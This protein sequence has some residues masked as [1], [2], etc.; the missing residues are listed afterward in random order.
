[1]VRHERLRVLL[2]LLMIQYPLHT[3]ASTRAPSKSRMHAVGEMLRQRLQGQ[4]ILC[5]NGSDGLLLA[6]PTVAL[7]RFF[8]LQVQPQLHSAAAS[9]ARLHQRIPRLN[10][11]R[12]RCQDVLQ[13]NIDRTEMFV[14][15]RFAP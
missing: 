14:S 15:E 10:R 5:Q 8:Q 2:V 12:R 6:S 4:R 13:R 7:A 11:S 3:V 1:M 9:V